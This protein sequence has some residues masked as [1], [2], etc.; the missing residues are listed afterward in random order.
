MIHNVE[1]MC[2]CGYMSIHIGLSLTKND[3]TYEDIFNGDI[4]EEKGFQLSF[5]KWTEKKTADL[6]VRGERGKQENKNTRKNACY[7]TDQCQYFFF[8]KKEMQLINQMNPTR[9]WLI[10]YSVKI[11]IIQEN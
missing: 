7:Y 5:Q 8:K 10:L 4:I 11:L 9:I 2:N 1:D 3:V 6:V